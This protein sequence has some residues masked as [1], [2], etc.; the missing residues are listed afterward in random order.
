MLGALL[1]ISIVWIIGLLYIKDNDFDTS[2][3][4]ID[5]DDPYVIGFFLLIILVG[6]IMVAVANLI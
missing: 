6:S 3:N 4:S 2:L 1:L 5:K